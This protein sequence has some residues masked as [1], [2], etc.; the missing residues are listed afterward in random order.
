MNRR[1]FTTT[2]LGTVAAASLGL[3]AGADEARTE[4]ATREATPRAG[5]L[6]ISFLLYEGMTA[7][8][9]IGPA[10]VLAVQ[11]FSVDFVARDRNPVLAESRSGNRLGLLPTATF[12]DIGA[13]DVLCVPGTSNPYAQMARPDMIEWVAH[14][15]GGATWVTS[16]CTGS[17]ILGAAGLLRGYRA[18]SHW[19]LVDQLAH[20]GATPVR[21]RVVHDRNRVTG[22]GVTSGIDF[23]LVLLSLLCGETA[24]RARQLI[25][26]YDPK[27]PFNSGSPVAADRQ[28]VHD[29]NANYAEYLRHVAPDAQRL[30]EQSA[31]R[32]GIAP[33]R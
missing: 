15:G 8:D 33:S 10:E 19:S 11:E 6:H 13:T 7:L 28:L 26:E 27:P 18:T 22:A 25:L 24:A 9:M 17:F 20:F 31:Q 23:G 30:L 5:K 29:A 32:L 12:S 1:D 4:P 3:I 16:V 14:A 2:C 21:H